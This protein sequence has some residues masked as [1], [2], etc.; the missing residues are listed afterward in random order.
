MQI[1]S[2][3][4]GWE[5]GL[6]FVAKDREDAIRVLETLKDRRKIAEEMEG[7]HLVVKRYYYA[8]IQTILSVEPIPD[9]QLSICKFANHDLQVVTAEF[10]SP[11]QKVVLIPEGTIYNG[12]P[13]N[14]RRLRKV[15]SYGLIEHRLQ[16]ENLEDGTDVSD[17][18]NVKS[19]YRDDKKREEVPMTYE[20]LVDT[21]RVQEAISGT[22]IG[23]SGDY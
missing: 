5:G 3:D 7:T 11:G 10:Y 23:F 21:F 19:Q 4:W 15:W 20:I 14:K 1:Y 17:Q 22:I 2:K 12:V 9:T 13:I 8:S 18:Y 6:V 16:Y